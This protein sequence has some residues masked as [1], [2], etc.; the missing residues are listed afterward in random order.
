MIERSVEAVAFLETI[1]RSKNWVASCWS[2][3][4]RT[5][6][7]LPPIS[8]SGFARRVGVICGWS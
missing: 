2:M 1:H 3:A 4:A 7:T 5:T 6:Q 8:T